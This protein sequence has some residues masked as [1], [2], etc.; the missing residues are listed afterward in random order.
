MAPFDVQVIEVVTGFVRSNILHHG[1]FAPEGSLYLPIKRRVEEYKNQG[2]ANGMTTE[3][4][5]KRVVQHVMKSN[6]APEL[7]EGKLA[8]YLWVLVTC[9]P[10]RLLVSW[11]HD[12][13]ALD[14][15]T[16]DALTLNTFE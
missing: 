5:A 14:A 4:Y 10:I 6:P 15:I 11:N 16:Q 13:L 8:T 2:N 1:L 3:E 9:L 7:W 12:V